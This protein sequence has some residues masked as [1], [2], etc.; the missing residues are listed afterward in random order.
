[1]S[2]GE[3]MSFLDHLEALRWHLLRSSAAVVVFA[4]VAFFAK[5]FVFHEVILG[6]S[7]V[8]FWTFRK[9]CELGE[10]IGS[11]ALCINS[12]DF[13]LQSRQM[14]GQFTMHIS[15]SILI[16]LICAFPYAFWEVWR[17]ISPGLYPKERRLVRGITFYV[18]LLFL[19]G[20]LFGYYIAAPLSINF[21]ADY[22]LD[23]S[24]QNQ[25]DITSYIGTLSMIVLSSGLMF[26][27]PIV[28]FFLSKAGIV[29][30]RLMRNY[31]RHAIIVILIVAAV[32]T[33]PD[34]FSQVLISLPLL[35]LYEM[36]IFISAYIEKKRTLS[37]E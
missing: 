8:D 36:S 15:S 22:K 25:F 9:L 33:P 21:L 13:S 30:P 27:L 23:P 12:L 14:S 37:N 34:V 17:F 10:Y 26:Q 29:T 2:Q 5:D 3:E 32:L 4:I 7:R 11:D 28:V 19:A 1:V 6:P 20:I 16:G 24:I 35:F 31:R 18:S